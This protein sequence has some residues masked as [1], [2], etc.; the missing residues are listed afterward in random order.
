MA[1]KLNQ[2]F[3]GLIIN[4]RNSSLGVTCKLIFVRV[5]ILVQTHYGKPLICFIIKILRDL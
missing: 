3:L 4:I 2:I 5:D 1:T